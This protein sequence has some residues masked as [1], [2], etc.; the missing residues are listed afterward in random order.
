MLHAN[1]GLAEEPLTCIQEGRFLLSER[2]FV[3]GRDCACDTGRED[4]TPEPSAEMWARQYEK[5][6][7][8]VDGCR[9]LCSDCLKV[10]DGTYIPEDV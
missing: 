5:L 10:E 3:Q 7:E 1:G 4:E 9:V 6:P 2:P 8:N